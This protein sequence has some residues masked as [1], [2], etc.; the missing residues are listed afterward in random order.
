[1]LRPHGYA[2]WSGGGPPI[3]RDTVQCCHC[4][5]VIYV[6]PGHGPR[7]FLVWVLNAWR[8]IPGMGC[9]KCHADVCWRCYQIGTC[10]PFER[11]IEAMEP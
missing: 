1:M 10:R 8:E 11:Q 6:K 3:E 5:A 2:V 4:Q 7:T 9:A